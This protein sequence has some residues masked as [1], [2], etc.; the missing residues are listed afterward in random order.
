[1]KRADR[2]DAIVSLVQQRAE[3]SVRDLA[4]LLAVPEATARRDLK[5]L[6]EQN[7]IRRSYGFAH[8]LDSEESVLRPAQIDPSSMMVAEAAGK[9]VTPGNVVIVPRGPINIELAGRLQRSETV[10][11]ITNSCRVFD[12]MKESPTAHIV[13]LGGVYSR[14][15]DCT[16]GPVAENSLLEMRADLLMLEPAGIDLAEGITHDNIV[17]LSLLKTMIRAARRVILLAGCDVFGKTSGA[18]IARI[19]ACSTVISAEPVPHAYAAYFREHGI[20][21]IEALA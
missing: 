9:I 16:Y 1:M 5:T 2:L 10:T 8:A 21:V 17:E 20:E 18:V 6:H 14:I 3:V 15:G 13:S 7:R 19:E 12:T 4:Q 11:V